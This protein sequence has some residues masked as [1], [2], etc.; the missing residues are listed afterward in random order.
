MKPALVLITG[1]LLFIVACGQRSDKLHKPSI[2]L[3]AERE[4]PVG[5]V[6]F[7]AYADSSFEYSLVPREVFKGSYVLKG[8]SL[9]LNCADSSI[10]INKVVIGEQ[11]LQFFGKKSPK[12]AGIIVNAL[13]K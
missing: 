3:Y 12:F 11:S 8:D 10:G 1:L 13:I 4:A 6:Q 5:R 9:F 2:L 7:T